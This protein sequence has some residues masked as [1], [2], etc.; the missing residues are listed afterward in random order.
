MK[1]S[2]QPWHEPVNNWPCEMP[3]ITSNPPSVRWLARSRRAG[4]TIA[5]GCHFVNQ[6]VEKLAERLKTETTDLEGW[7]KLVRAY[8][9]LGR[10]GDATAALATA[11]KSLSADQKAI[12][13]LDGLAKELGLG[14]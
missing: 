10:D 13:A 11:R 12:S 4:G 7:L 2:M 8:K 3:P 1:N 14:S 6:M 9:V 5:D